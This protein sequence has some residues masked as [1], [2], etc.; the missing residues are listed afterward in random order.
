MLM[1]CF[2]TDDLGAKNH[3]WLLKLGWL[4]FK[5]YLI[6]INVNVSSHIWLV[7]AMLTLDS[8]IYY[9]PTISK[10]EKSPN[11]LILCPSQVILKESD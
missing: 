9:I 2:C 7:T 4:N 1:F 5:F 6:L 3:M 11:T 10:K 8:E